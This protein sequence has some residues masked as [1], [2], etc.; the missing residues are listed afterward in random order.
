MIADIRRVH[1]D[2]EETGAFGRLMKMESHLCKAMESHGREPGRANQ[3]TSRKSSW[4]VVEMVYDD[5]GDFL[6]LAQPYADG[7][8]TSFLVLG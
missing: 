4:L 2:V 5:V 8:T 7:E 6:A 3:G 1:Q